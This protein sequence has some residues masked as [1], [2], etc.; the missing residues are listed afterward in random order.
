MGDLLL[1]CAPDREP[2]VSNRDGG[3]QTISSAQFRV[4]H[5]PNSVASSLD[6]PIKPF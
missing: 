1:D 6:E 3:G 5:S 2:A 4:C